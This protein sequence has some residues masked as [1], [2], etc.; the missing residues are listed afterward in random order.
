MGRF[1]SRDFGNDRPFVVKG[2]KGKLLFIALVAMGC[3]WL[4]NVMA[5]GIGWIIN[6]L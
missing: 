4:V 3:M 5:M 1:D 2:W 6:E